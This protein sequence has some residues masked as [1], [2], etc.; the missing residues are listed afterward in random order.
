MD[1]AA[2]GAVGLEFRAIQIREQL[3]NLMLLQRTTH[4]HRA[5]TSELFQPILESRFAAQAEPVLAHALDHIRKQLA[6]SA[7]AEH[8][9]RA[10]EDERGRAERFDLEAQR[11]QLGKC[12]LNLRRAGRVQFERLGR[13]HRLGLDPTGAKL[14]AQALEGDALVRSVLIDEEQPFVGFERDIAGEELADNAEA[15]VDRD[16]GDGSRDGSGGRRGCRSRPDGGSG[17]VA[18]AERALLGARGRGVGDQTQGSRRIRA[19]SRG[20]G[21]FSRTGR[22]CGGCC[23]ARRIPC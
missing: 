10:L 11:M 13:Q 7:R 2:V 1:R 12:A 22:G 21:C 4:P 16:G 6:S 15:R 14:R 18:Q 20:G 5:V 19:A 3:D 17:C 9:R 8:R 23:R